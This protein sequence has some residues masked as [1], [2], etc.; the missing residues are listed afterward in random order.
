MRNRNVASAS[1]KGIGFSE[2]HLCWRPGELLYLRSFPLVPWSQWLSALIMSLQKLSPGRLLGFLFCN[3]IW[4]NYLQTS[5]SKLA[6]LS[7]FLHG[8]FRAMANCNESK[9]LIKKFSPTNHS[10]SNKKKV[11]YCSQG[12][13]FALMTGREW[14]FIKCVGVCGCAVTSTVDNHHFFIQSTLP[15][16]FLV[17]VFRSWLVWTVSELLVPSGFHLDFHWVVPAGAQKEQ[18]HT[19]MILVPLAVSFQV[20][21]LLIKDFALLKI[22]KK[23]L[24]WLCPWSSNNFSHP[25]R[26]WPGQ[27]EIVM[28]F[29][30]FK[31]HENWKFLLPPK[32]QGKKM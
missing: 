4:Y 8:W 14:I 11:L 17:F 5:I 19:I 1:A 29:V 9:I 26:L 3:L 22:K 15:I 32:K 16:S 25:F 13:N 24:I 27:W 7:T 31:I 18:E 23:N 21:C 30:I 6:H 28:G 20:I 2:K 12:I 10:T